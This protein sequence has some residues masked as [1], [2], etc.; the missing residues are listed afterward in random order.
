MQSFRLNSLPA[1]VLASFFMLVLPASPQVTGSANSQPGNSQSTTSSPSQTTTPSSQQPA[2][3][4]SQS[5]GTSSSQPSNSNAMP[6]AQPVSPSV[7][8]A[9]PSAQP[10]PQA[11]TGGTGEYTGPNKRNP[12][13]NPAPASPE[14]VKPPAEPMPERRNLEAA[15]AALEE[16]Q[17]LLKQVDPAKTKN[18]DRAAVAVS[19]SIRHTQAAI[20]DVSSSTQSLGAGRGTS[21]G[22][23][24]TGGTGEFT[25]P[26]KRKTDIGSQEPAAKPEKRN[27][28]AALA[29][30]EEAQ[31]L[32]KQVDSAKTKNR[33]RALTAAN[34]ASRHTEAAIKDLSPSK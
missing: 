12:D 32:L 8:P 33:N 29:A 23:S 26:N 24:A 17:E 9:S 5:G 25:G 20:K 1:A 21:S 28:E 2:T 6:A 22:Q 4:P 31:E 30:L 18:R 34:N 27:L 16:A 13:V 14:E 3:T 7:Q 11:A 19:I 10:D 15:L